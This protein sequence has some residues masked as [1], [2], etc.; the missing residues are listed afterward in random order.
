VAARQRSAHTI[1]ILAEQSDIDHAARLV[2]P[3]LTPRLSSAHA[4]V[5]SDVGTQ[6]RVSGQ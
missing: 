4:N 2:R 3:L 1:G 5:S 6:V